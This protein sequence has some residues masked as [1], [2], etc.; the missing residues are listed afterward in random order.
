MQAVIEWV[1]G[2]GHHLA[3]V[4]PTRRRLAASSATT[5][6]W[7]NGSDALAG[8]CRALAVERGSPSAT[9]S[10][11]LLGAGGLL[12]PPHGRPGAGPADRPRRAA[13]AT[14]TDVDPWSPAPTPRRARPGQASVGD[15]V[16]MPEAALAVARRG[17]LSRSGARRG[18]A[19]A[20]GE[21]P[22][23]T[24]GPARRPARRRRGTVRPELHRRGAE[25]HV[26][27]LAAGVEV[28]S[29]PRAS[30]PRPISAGEIEA[31]PHAT[32]TRRGSR[33]TSGARSFTTLRRPRQ[34]RGPGHR[35]GARRALARRRPRRLDH[36]RRQGGGRAPT[37]C[38]GPS[39]SPR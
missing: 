32:T 12:P 14:A 26:R 29:A 37:A 27:T 30:R 3:G 7:G 5:R 4:R 20:R 34:A 9:P 16:G 36:L 8:P 21:G 1:G 35:S 10:P 6:R 15:N 24:P 2:R 33:S 31:V 18:K 17:G 11:P 39:R 28:T 19:G 38:A 13:L 22:Q 23:A 25:V